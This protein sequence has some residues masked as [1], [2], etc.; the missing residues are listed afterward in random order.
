MQNTKAPAPAQT[1]AAAITPTP[2][3]EVKTKATPVEERLYKMI[4]EPSL[5]PKGKQR[6]IVLA[7]LKASKEPLTVAQV[8]AEAVKLNLSAVGGV[9]P[10]CRYHLHHLVLLKIAEVTNPTV[11]IETVVK[12]AATEKKEETVAA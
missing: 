5:P 6:Q 11:E 10:S 2:A 9:G 7:I 4:N 12:P 1:T 8:T 3:V